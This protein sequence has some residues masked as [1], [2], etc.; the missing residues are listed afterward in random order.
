VCTKAVTLGVR[1]SF[2]HEA[3]KRG[4]IEDLSD[5]K[6]REKDDDAPVIFANHICKPHGHVCNFIRSYTPPL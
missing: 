5:K 4:S 2:T 6:E 1:K 3:I